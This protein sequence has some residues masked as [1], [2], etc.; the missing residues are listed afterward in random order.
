MGPKN[1]PKDI[2]AKLN[3]AVLKAMADP[4]IRPKLEAQ[5]VQFGT[6]TTPDEFAAFIKAELT[7]YQRL[8]KELNVKAE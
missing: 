2:V 3:D 4:A 7:K 6:M 8:V 5:G 1:L